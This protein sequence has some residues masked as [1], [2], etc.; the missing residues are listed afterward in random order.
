MQE[1]FYFLLSFFVLFF[2]HDYRIH[3]TVFDSLPDRSQCSLQV[4]A[5]SLS[6]S[7]YFPIRSL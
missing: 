6:Q 4:S 5:L 3:H 7:D 1:V 2:V